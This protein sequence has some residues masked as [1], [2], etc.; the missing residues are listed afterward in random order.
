MTPEEL[1]VRPT[2]LT[3]VLGEAVGQPG[4]G[5]AEQVIV[6][7]HLIT[8]LEKAASAAAGL[9]PTQLDFDESI[10]GSRH[11]KQMEARFEKIEQAQ[12]KTDGNVEIVIGE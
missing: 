7:K 9:K 12:V 5:Y 8:R 10:A 1:R 6:A 3:S 4:P 2:D 11:T